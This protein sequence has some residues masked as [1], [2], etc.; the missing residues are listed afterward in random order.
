VLKLFAAWLNTFAAFAE[1]R[2]AYVELFD[3][4]QLSETA[5]RE[6][7]PELD[8]QQDAMRYRGVYLISS[9]RELHRH[10]ISKK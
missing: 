4:G 1:E 8:A 2:S 9:V 6:L 5:F 3:K 7:T 10:R